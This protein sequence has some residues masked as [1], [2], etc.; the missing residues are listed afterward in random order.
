MVLNTRH[1]GIVV[2]DLDR[3]IRFYEGLGMQVAA[4]MVEQG[5]YI[6]QLVGLQ[7]TSLEWAK[8]RLPDQSLVELLQYH[9]HPSAESRTP[10][11]AANRPGCSHIAFTVRNMEETIAY[12]SGNGGTVNR[13]FQFSPD[14][15]V[16]VVYAYDPEG[17]ILEI[18]EVLQ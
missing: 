5:A 16:K 8:L 4:R 10:L 9:S 1:T 14:G 3:A 7:Q 17:N 12:I 18:V 6:D 13:D 2:D 11:Q 15:K